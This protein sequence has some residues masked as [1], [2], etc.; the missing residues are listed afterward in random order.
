MISFQRLARDHILYVRVESKTEFLKPHVKMLMQQYLECLFCL[1]VV[2]NFHGIKSTSNAA[3]LHMHQYL[4]HFL[5]EPIT[6]HASYIGKF[7][8]MTMGHSDSLKS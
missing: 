6:V 5:R 3:K 4:F 7:I 1:D 2:K 8:A